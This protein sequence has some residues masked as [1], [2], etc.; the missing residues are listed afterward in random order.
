VSLFVEL[1]TSKRNKKN[2][3]IS[4]FYKLKLVFEQIFLKK[5]SILLLINNKISF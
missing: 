4:S 2:I 3:E 5:K 1:V